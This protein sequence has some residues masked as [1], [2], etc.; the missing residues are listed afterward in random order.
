VPENNYENVDTDYIATQH[1]KWVLGNFDVYPRNAPT[2]CYKF[3][4]EC[5]HKSDCDKFEM[6]KESLTQI[7]HASYSSDEVFKLCPE[8]YRRYKLMNSKEENYDSQSFMGTLMHR[9]LAEI[10]NQFKENQ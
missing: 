8:K 10:Y 1:Q 6:P 4:E 5:I 7:T 2:A 9:G 3:G